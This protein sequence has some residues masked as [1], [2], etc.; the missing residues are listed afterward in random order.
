MTN[1]NVM[2][3]LDHPVSC[4]DGMMWCNGYRSGLITKSCRFKPQQILPLLLL[5]K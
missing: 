1:V 5:I 3:I 4:A 2:N